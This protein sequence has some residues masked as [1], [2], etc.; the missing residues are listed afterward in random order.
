MLGRDLKPGEEVVLAKSNSELAKDRKSRIFICEGGN[1]MKVDVP[2]GVIYGKWKYNSEDGCIR[3]EHIDVEA[4]RRLQ[5]KHR[6]F[7]ERG[8]GRRRM[9][10]NPG[11]RRYRQPNL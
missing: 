6:M 2:G 9:S 10:R 11:S 4:T 5:G 7:D 1:G 3:A 8:T